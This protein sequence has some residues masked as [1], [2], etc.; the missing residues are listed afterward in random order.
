MPDHHKVEAMRDLAI[1]IRLM[2][3][4]A[5]SNERDRNEKLHRLLGEL[6][7]VGRSLQETA[8]Q[9]RIWMALP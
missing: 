7:A 3:E 6:S 2:M 5:F 9:K 1:Q 4:T 8:I